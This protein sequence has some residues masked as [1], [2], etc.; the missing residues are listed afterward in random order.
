MMEMYTKVLDGIKLDAI[1][2]ITMRNRLA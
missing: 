2:R 1:R